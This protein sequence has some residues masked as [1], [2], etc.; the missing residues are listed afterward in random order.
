MNP[1]NQVDAIK[2]ATEAAAAIQSHAP[3][4]PLHD[5][6]G[7]VLIAQAVDRQTELL[8][9][10]VEKLALFAPFVDYLVKEFEEELAK[11]SQARG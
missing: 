3:A 6:L 4:V 10:V 1:L 2:Q 9:P 5:L 8:R 7:H 11:K